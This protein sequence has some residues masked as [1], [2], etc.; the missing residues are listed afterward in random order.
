MATALIVLCIVL[1]V[2]LGVG[3]L[4]FLGIGIKKDKAWRQR[5]RRRD[6]VRRR[7][8]RAPR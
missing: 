2:A 8:R 6:A 7:M 5:I 1:C 4:A 3:V